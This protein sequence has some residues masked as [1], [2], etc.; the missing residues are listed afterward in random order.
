MP[1]LTEPRHEW[2]DESHQEVSATALHIHDMMLFWVAIFMSP[3]ISMS[4]FLT[5]INRLNTAWSNRGNG[6]VAETE[7]ANALAALIVILNSLAKYVGEQANGDVAIINKAGMQATFTSRNPAV[8]CAATDTPTGSSEKGGILNFRVKKTAGALSYFWIIF[9]LGIVDVVIKGKTISFPTNS[10]VIIIPVGS[11]I[12]KLE[13]LDGRLEV[14]IGV[15]G[16]NPAGIGP[17]SGLLT[18]DT[19][20]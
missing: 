7:L 19:L 17:M 12:E 16:V 5:A 4:V 8:K 15:C 2:N 18:L 14:K 11:S 13:G 20:K 1:N 6:L 3:P 9:T 10:G